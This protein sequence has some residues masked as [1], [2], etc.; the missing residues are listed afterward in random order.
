MAYNIEKY[1]VA[2]LKK[3]GITIKEYVSEIEKIEIS[4]LKGTKITLKQAIKKK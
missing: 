4:T 3:S 1:V 2:S